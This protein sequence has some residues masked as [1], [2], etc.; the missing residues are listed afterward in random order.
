[1]YQVVAVNVGPKWDPDYVRR[2]MMAMKLFLPFEHDY[3]VITDAPEKYP[4]C[5]TL[6]AMDN[7]KDYW[8][9]VTMFAPER[10]EQ[11]KSNR[12]IYMDLDTVILN[13]IE[14]LIA[15]PGHLLTIRDRIL[16][17]VNSSLLVWD[18]DKFTHVYTE[19]DGPHYIRGDQEYIGTKTDPLYANEIF[20]HNLIPDFKEDLR[21]QPPGGHEMLVW[22]HGVPY[23]HTLQWVQNRWRDQQIAYQQMRG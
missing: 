5:R 11:Y 18:F 2:Q 3:A 9:K 17:M 20:G 16:P 7:L 1:M 10:K 23:P 4:F 21:H 19:F 8:Q 13:S 12:I 15:Y 22:F 14:R 6:P